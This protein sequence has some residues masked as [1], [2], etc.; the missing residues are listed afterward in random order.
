MRMAFLLAVM[1]GFTLSASADVFEPKQRFLGMR[2]N[3]ARVNDERVTEW[4]D[5]T[6]VPKLAGQPIFDPANPFRWLIDQAVPMPASPDAFVEFQGGDCLPGRVVDFVPAESDSFEAH[7][8]LLV[9]E[10]LMSIDLPGK[11]TTPFIRIDTRWLRRVVFQKRSTNPQR[12]RP[13]TVFLHDGSQLAFRVVRWSEA[14]L[15]ILTENG[16]QTL[17]FS[18]VAELHMPTT[19]PWDV[20]FEQLATLSPEPRVTTV[21]GGDVNGPHTDRLGR[22]LPA[23]VQRRQKQIRELVPAV[24]AG[25]EPRSDLRSV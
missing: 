3:G 1:L 10:P 15:S 4:H 8:E 18:Q 5:Q 14:A 9:V 13:G 24:S 25:V 17:L 11:P 7:G 20:Y 2:N 21:S 19:N 16:V 6:A 12:Y 22:A 23:S